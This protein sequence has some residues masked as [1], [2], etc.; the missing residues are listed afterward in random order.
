MRLFK[1]S[2]R[3]PRVV[4]LGLD[5]VPWSYLQRQFDAGELP[6]LRALVE[7]GALAQMDTTVP[8]VSSTAWATFMTGA[9][10]GKHGI[11]GFVDRTPGTMKTYVPT[12]RNLRLP[13]VW[14][15]LSEHGKRV[16]SMNVPGTFPSRPAN[17][18]II[19][20]FLS[21]SVAK[22]APN[23]KVA[24][25]LARFG[26]ILDAD[27]VLAH[28]D[29]GKFLDHLE[30]VLDRRMTALRHFWHQEQ[31][32]LFVAHVMETDRMHHFL[33][34][35]MDEGH[36]EYAP[37]FLE[38]YKRVDDAVGEVRSW[39]DEDT[40]LVVLSD[41]GFTSIRT[42]LNV[43]TWLRSVGEL[44]YTSDD[45]KGLPDL[46]PSSRAYALDPGR[47]F[48]NV[49]GREPEGRIAPGAE[50]ERVRDELA[51]AAL[52]ITD[53]ETGA[54]MVA[55]VF[56]REELYA[57]PE[58]E[59]GADLVLEMH[60]GDDAKGTFGRPEVS[61][62]GPALTGMHT[63]PDA[64]LYVSGAEGFDRRPQMQDVAPTLCAL[65]GAPVPAEMDGR[66]LTA[67]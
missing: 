14:E 25:D 35:E 24:E 10:P 15:V 62:K 56:R 32:D 19:G 7:G 34:G 67:A 40:R 49:Q 5:G 20:D 33:W 48:L 29:K 57:G 36:P 46:D 16:F 2:P 52:G 66:P 22:A 21:P 60:D 31:W 1:R 4:V 9:N 13:T 42:E 3:K 11:Y 51:E 43:N 59:R 64:F 8:N 23:A 63:T 53:P 6:N 55:K 44:S 54:P 26:Y 50:Y 65:L 28:R 37:R 61:A 39:L 45:A 58:A 12:S 47:I 27:P 30:E 18:T 38:V 41:H 17:G